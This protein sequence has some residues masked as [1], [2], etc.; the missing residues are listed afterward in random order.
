MGSILILLM[1]DC[2]APLPSYV[3][4]NVD[5]SVW[6][7]KAMYGRLLRDEAGCWQWN[8]SGFC[9]FSSPLYAE[10]MALKEGLKGIHQH[11]YLW[12]I[13]ESDSSGWYNLSTVFRMKTI[14]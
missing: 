8:L 7:G 13:V 3:K 11:L 14:H 10:L 1:V 9:G 12:I 2:F 6:D 4:L 5:G